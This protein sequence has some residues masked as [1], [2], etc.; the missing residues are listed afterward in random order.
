MRRRKVS[1]I[2]TCM[3]DGARVAASEV[4]APEGE[5]AKAARGGRDH[6]SVGDVMRDGRGLVER[7]GGGGGQG[8]EMVA[9][10]HARTNPVIALP[11]ESYL[12]VLLAP[13]PS[14]GS[15]QFVRTLFRATVDGP[16]SVNLT[17]VGQPG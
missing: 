9:A 5:Q 2:S 14:I 3:N 12:T 11:L 6:A 16:R 10:G 13:P 7:G 1:H 4:D 8:I 17:I 15:H